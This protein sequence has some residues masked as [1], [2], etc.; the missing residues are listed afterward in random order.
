M[1][2]LRVLALALL[3][4]SFAAVAKPYPDK[5]R[6]IRVVVPFGPGSGHDIIA[7]AYAR[8]LNEQ[9]GLTVIVDNRPGA[10]G[11][12]GV[13][14][15]KNA[16]PDGY[17]LL[18]GNTS[19]MVLNVH[20]MPTVRYDPLADFTP[21]TGV[22]KFSLVVN[23]GPSTKFKSARELIEAART[24]PGKY[25]YGYG[26]ASTRLAMELLEHSAKVKMLSVPYKTMAQATSALSSGEIDVLVNDV[27]TA[28]PLYKAGRV[29]PIAATGGK[30]LAAL[31]AVPT[32]RE[33]GVEDYELSGWYAWFVPVHTSPEVIATLGS[34]LREAAHSKH[35]ADALALNSFDPLD[36]DTAQLTAL[37][38]ADIERWGKQRAMN[39]KDGR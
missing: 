25:T 36:L 20:M 17:T 28:V 22:A 4:V 6:T 32:L 1:N 10:E 38:R 3:A 14:A 16:A 26:S 35:V 11:I 31:P 29:R 13:E 18:L 9:A 30:R 19:T 7:R 23:A 5:S 33:Q 12:I 2:I 39:M 15:A 34:M 21:V 24:N 37:N 27:A 8:A